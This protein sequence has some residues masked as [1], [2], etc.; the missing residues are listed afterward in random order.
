MY[1]QNMIAPMIDA[2]IAVT[3]TAPAATSLAWPIR[4]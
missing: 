3:K 1:G 2:P 4:G